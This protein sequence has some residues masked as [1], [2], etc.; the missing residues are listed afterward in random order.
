MVYKYKNNDKNNW[1]CCPMGCMRDS[2]V[3]ECYHFGKVT[4]KYCSECTVRKDN[5]I[6]RKSGE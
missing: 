3:V 6:I 5:K 1:T 2:T 4:L